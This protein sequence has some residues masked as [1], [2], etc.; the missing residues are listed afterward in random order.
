MVAT[1]GRLWLVMMAGCGVTAAAT[2]AVEGAVRGR[3]VGGGWW[4]VRARSFALC[5]R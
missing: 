4:C 3:C 2:A 5:W 1:S